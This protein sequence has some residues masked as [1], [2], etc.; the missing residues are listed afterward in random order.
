MI[1]VAG[2]NQTKIVAAPGRKVGMASSNSPKGGTSS[3]N[4]LFLAGFR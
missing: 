2:T 1:K 3:T 4:K